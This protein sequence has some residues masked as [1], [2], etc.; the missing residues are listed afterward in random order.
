MAHVFE[1][2]GPSR[3]INKSS[4]IHFLRPKGY[5]SSHVMGQ[6]CD[7]F[8][9]KDNLNGKETSAMGFVTVTEQKG[10]VRT[11]DSF[12]NVIFSANTFAF[13]RRGKERDAATRA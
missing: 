13:E 8:F 12:H 4:R 7:I 1:K 3:H 5:H 6:F 11:N 9:V 2:F 10:N